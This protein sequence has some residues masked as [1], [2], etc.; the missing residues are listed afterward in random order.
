MFMTGAAFSV[1]RPLVKGRAAGGL[2][3]NLGTPKLQVP[4]SPENSPVQVL[5]MGPLDLLQVTH[6]S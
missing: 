1:S 3:S 6:Y 4:V 2:P 5:S